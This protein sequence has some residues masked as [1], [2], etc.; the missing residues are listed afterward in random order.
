MYNIKDASKKKDE[1]LYHPLQDTA[2]Q[3]I[4]VSFLG[5]V[6]YPERQKY[7]QHLINTKTPLYV[8]GGQREKGLS[9]M[10]YAELM[11]HSKISLNFPEGP[12]GNDQCKGRVW[13]ILASKSLLLE[14]KNT[15]IQN[16]LKPN[17]HYVE[18]DNEEDL[19][20]KIQYYLDNE[21][22]R[23]Y[24]VNKGYNLYKKKYNATTFW[25]NIMKELNCEL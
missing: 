17:V 12:E 24:I 10:R 6:R 16:F 21:N 3:Q 8:D 1:T 15:P 13:E 7:L 2:T 19:V 25:S 22:E 5:S 18:F 20:E 9:P 23:E 4:P 11:R 14:R